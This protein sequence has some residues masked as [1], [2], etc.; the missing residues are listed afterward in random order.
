MKN[1]PPLCLC[2]GLLAGFA[3]A[4]AAAKDKGLDILISADAISPPEGFRPKPGKPIHY[5]LFQSRQTLGEVVAGVKLPDPALVE[6]A[7]VAELEKQ[8]FVRTQEGGPIPEIVV[9]TVVG[10]ANF[11]DEII[12]PG[13]P[14]IDDPEFAGYMHAVDVR[15]V[16]IGLGLFGKVP[17]SVEDLFDPLNPQVWPSKTREIADAQEAVINEARRLRNLDPAR[18]RNELKT[19]MGANKIDR[20]VGSRTLSGTEAERIATAAFDNQ[21]YISLNALEAMKQPEG[22]RRFLWRTTMLVDWRE[23]FSKALPAILAQA[24][25]LF[26]TDVAVPGF[27]NTAKPRE[28]KVEIGEA[29][30][31]P[32]KDP[33][34]APAMP[35]RKK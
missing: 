28:G 31:V 19:L 2:L 29:T 7:V 22:G 30:V 23:D 24:G 21:F 10:D 8:G 11:K 3:V 26:G 20:A 27:V 5:L 6:R 17:N 34:R 25:P 1:L 33:A 14:L 4:A 16:T 18:K 13:N 32:E 15:H 35:A 9:V 12:R